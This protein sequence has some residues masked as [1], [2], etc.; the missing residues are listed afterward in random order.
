MRLK[1]PAHIYIRQLIVTEGENGQQKSGSQDTPEDEDSG[2]DTGDDGSE[3]QDDQG[4]ENDDAGK[5]AETK[6]D[7]SGENSKDADTENDTSG[8]GI[9]DMDPKEEV[10]GKEQES[11]T[12]SVKYEKAGDQ[13]YTARMPVKRNTDNSKT[14]VTSSVKTGDHNTNLPV[15]IAIA[16][17]VTC[18]ISVL[19][20]R[21]KKKK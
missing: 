5:D 4:D 9:N 3:P 13:A 19:A 21:R 18:L 8:N 11:A 14:T 12:P 1:H 6:D 17:F 16:A 7:P 10:S 15:F 2:T 20:V